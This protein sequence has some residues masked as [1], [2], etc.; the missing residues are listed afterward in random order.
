MASAL[1][2]KTFATRSVSHLRALALC[3][4]FSFALTALASNNRKTFS[5]FEIEVESKIGFFPSPGY[6]VSILGSGRVNYHGYDR[7]HWKGRRHARISQDAV[8][9]LVEHV[10]ASKFL[11]LPGSYENGPCLAID[12]SEG[13]LRVRLDGR[14]KSVGTCGAPPIV[15]QLMGEVVSVA[16][17]WRW[18]VFDPDELRHQVAQGWH[19]SEQMPKI[20]EDAISWDAAELIRIL[21]SNGADANGLNTDNEHFLTGAVR[22]GHVEAAQA[23]LEAG[24]DWKAED[25]DD[26]NSATAAGFR[27]PEM[28]K[29]LLDKGVDP[30][31]LSTAGH[32]MLMNA[33]Y[34]ANLSTVQLLVDAGA[35]VNIRNERGESA[36]SIAKAR[37]K[38]YSVGAPDIASSFQ[39]IIDYLVAHGAVR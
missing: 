31:A 21:V 39:P 4:V 36:L 6:T 7:V 14:E 37:K 3:A 23:L 26:E 8:E 18:V 22:S 11:D 16:R 12:N 20:M 19:V 35:D 34:L 2:H 24:A 32:T 15:D 9:Q 27:G 38:E 5:S 28:V 13:S 17:V 29:V 33:T 10:R 1:T 25:S 30:N